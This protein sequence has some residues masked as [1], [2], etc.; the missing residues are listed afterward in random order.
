M[1]GLMAGTNQFRGNLIRGSN[2]GAAGTGQPLGPSHDRRPRGHEGFVARGARGA[3]CGRATSDDFAARPSRPG[4]TPGS[5]RSSEVATSGSAM[6][7]NCVDFTQPYRPH[8]GNSSAPSRS[9]SPCSA[10]GAAAECTPPPIAPTPRSGSRQR[11]ASEC[12]LSRWRGGIDLAVIPTKSAA[13]SALGGPALGSINT[14]R[15]C[16]CVVA[17]P[18]PAAGGRDLEWRASKNARIRRRTTRQILLAASAA[19]A[20]TRLLEGSQG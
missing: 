15:G 9:P 8:D 2:P 18:P 14:K 10:N 16:G 20:G 12:D 1:W 4:C 5:Q 17:S 3:F 13:K 19:S 6:T 11:W 7:E